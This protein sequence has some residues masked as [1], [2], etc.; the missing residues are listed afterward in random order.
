MTDTNKHKIW[1][2]LPLEIREALSREDTV[3]KIEAIA[4]KQGLSPIEQGFLVRICANLMRGIIKPEVFVATITDELDISRE[5]AAYLAQ[6]VN[7]DIF[8]PIKESL[9]KVHADSV[10][11]EKKEIVAKLDP[12]LVTCLPHDMSK[13]AAIANKAPGNTVAAGSIFEQKLGGAFRMKGE[14]VSSTGLSTPAPTLVTPPTLQPMR[15]API[16]TP[17]TTAQKPIDPYRE[18]PI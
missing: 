7:R 11:S 1:G 4:E 10:H 13:E 8:S 14:A 17:T 5:K 3:T 12:S 16:T 2:E 9:Q 6:E 15:P 18:H